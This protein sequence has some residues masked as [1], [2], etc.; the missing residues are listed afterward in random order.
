MSSP[1]GIALV[2]YGYWGP[3]LARNFAANAGCALRAIVELGDE[4]RELAGRTYPDAA[5]TA[6]YDAVLA[7]RDV[8]AVAIATPVS[9]HFDLARKALEAGKDVLIEKPMTETAAQSRQL[10]ELADANGRILAVDHTF[11]FTGA[12]AKI[13]Q[14]VDSG[15][16]GDVLYID[17]ARTNLGLFQ[18]DV[19]VMADLA[20][21][22]LSIVGY[23]L[24]RDPVSVRAL[25][26]AH[27][28]HEPEYIAYIH[29]EYAGGAIAHFHV[30]WLSP[31]KIRQMLV[32]GSQKMVVFDDNDPSEKVRIYDKGV[33]F[34]PGDTDAFYRLRV[35][36]RSGDMVAPKLERTEALAAEVEHFAAAV[37][38][39]TT[40]IADGRAG[41]AVVR[42]LEAA[43]QSLDT[44]G[45]KVMLS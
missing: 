26:A 44:G 17:S 28:Q 35:D 10:V 36:Y 37:R 31:V 8:D 22:D 29:L 1:V 18:Q 16:L 4:R 24:G 15:Q 30:N 39:R 3:N 43:Q 33:E 34:S 12:V 14:L 9:T 2:G 6:D 11:L 13:K 20:P 7:R 5:A 38:D 23:L 27:E 42:I 41:L 45:E 21:H 32:C 40:P 25:G 19:N